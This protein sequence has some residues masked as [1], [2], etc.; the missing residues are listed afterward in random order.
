MPVATDRIPGMDATSLLVCAFVFLSTRDEALAQV[1]LDVLY[2]YY[3][4]C[5]VLPYYS[6]PPVGHPSPPQ[7]AAV[8]VAAPPVTTVFHECLLVQGTKRNTP[9]WGRLSFPPREG[10]RE[11][12]LM[13]GA[14]ET[15][16]E[17]SGSRHYNNNVI[18]FHAP[19]TAF[20]G[21]GTRGKG[22]AKSMCLLKQQRSGLLTHQRHSLGQSAICSAQKIRAVIFSLCHAGPIRSRWCRCVFPS[23]YD[24]VRATRRPS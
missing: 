2:M 6:L 18:T 13:P 10:E 17:Y 21:T 5:K 19:N 24:A 1:Y 15:N 11:L 22:R 7:W 20:L 12:A 16:S 3:W 8:G 4:A 14:D 9:C 23:L